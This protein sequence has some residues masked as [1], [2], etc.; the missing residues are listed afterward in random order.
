M[1]W[2]ILILLAS[3][4]AVIY[5]ASLLQ[6]VPLPHPAKI[7]TSDLTRFQKPPDKIVLTNAGDYLYQTAV[8]YKITPNDREGFSVGIGP[9]K[10]NVVG[11]VKQLRKPLSSLLNTNQ[12]HEWTSVFEHQLAG[13]ISFVSDHGIPDLESKPFGVLYYTIKQDIPRF[14]VRL[15]YLSLA[16][17][18]FEYKDLLLP[19]SSWINAFTLEKDSILYSRDHDQYNFRFIPIPPTIFSPPHSVEYTMNKSEVGDAVPGTIRSAADDFTQ[20][21]G[22]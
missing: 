10:T 11:Y 17:M 22:S 9:M 2:R 18:T 20:P 7:N 5:L 19:G 15:Y 16:Q 3:G 13:P 8:W 14:Y 4:I 12:S 21:S 6:D 1:Q